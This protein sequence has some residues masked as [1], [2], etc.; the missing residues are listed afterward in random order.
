MDYEA[1]GYCFSQ[2]HISP[3]NV[4]ARQKTVAIQKKSWRNKCFN[5][6]ALQKPANPQTLLITPANSRI[7]YTKIANPQ[8]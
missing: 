4:S 5:L 1:K 3:Q 8:N 2:A 6:P 7:Q